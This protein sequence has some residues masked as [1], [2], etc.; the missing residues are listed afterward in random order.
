MSQEHSPR[1]PIMIGHEVELILVTRF[2]VQS[3]ATGATPPNCCAQE[4]SSS[5]FRSQGKSRST[6]ANLTLKSCLT[7]PKASSD[8]P[9]PGDSPSP[10]TNQRSA[11]NRV[12]PGGARQL[13]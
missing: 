10:W 13:R 3:A 12:E 8:A 2:A 1:S 7:L 6:G 5:T 4:R 9:V 11:S